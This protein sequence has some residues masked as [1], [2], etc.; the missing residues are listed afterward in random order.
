MNRQLLNEPALAVDE[1]QGHVLVGFGGARQALA[2]IE[3][4]DLEA[5]AQAV[6]TWARRGWVTSTRTLMPR[7]GHRAKEFVLRSG[8][9]VTIAVSPRLLAAAGLP[10]AF[11]DEWLTASDG[12]QGITE[13][14]D[15]QGEWVTGGRDHPVDVLMITAAGTTGAAQEL[16]DWFV[17]DRSWIAEEFRE[18]LNPLPGGIEHFG[19]R[20]G[21]SQP[22]LLGTVDG[23][24]FEERTQDPE[25]GSGSLYASPGRELV[26]P[27]EFVFGYP[28][29]H[30]HDGRRPGREAVAG[31]DDTSAMA[32]NG[33]LLVYRRLAQD[34]DAF[35]AFCADRAPAVGGSADRLEALLVGRWPSGTPV[36]ATSTTPAVDP[37]L[38]GF[39][40]R[41]DAMAEVCPRAAH[42]RKVNPRQGGSDL[43]NAVPRMLRRGAPYGPL[44]SESEADPPGGRGLA[45]ISYQTS[46]EGQFGQVTSD[47]MNDSTAP[48]GGGGYDL[49]VGQ[50]EPGGERFIDLEDSPAGR[51]RDGGQRW[52]TPTGGA[53]LVA[54][55]ITALQAL[56]RSEGS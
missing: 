42:I 29:R 26:W 52:V 34:V 21:I 40:F 22:A 45:F 50:A 10:V 46:I 13:L 19:F 14:H 9:W 4:D 27:G 47:W 36:A 6:G 32:R 37:V 7:K 44:R 56:A 5:A 48:T 12:M 1:I 35:R 24:P 8:P 17:A 41:D 3:A 16:I 53:F 43:D 20:D 11:D 30:R 49:L 28:R 39:T 15:P 51:I 38:N 33:S 18:S 55:S 2:A 54:P 31:D 23:E 25:D